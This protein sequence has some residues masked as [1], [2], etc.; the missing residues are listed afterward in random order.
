MVDELLRKVLRGKNSKNY[1]NEFELSHE[2]RCTVVHLPLILIE[3]TI[4]PLH[5]ARIK[6]VPLLAI[7]MIVFYVLTVGLTFPMH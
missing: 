2:E 1:G 7:K 3:I 6:R 4:L 5:L